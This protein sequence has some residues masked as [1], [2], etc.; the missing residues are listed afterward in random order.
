MNSLS[1]RVAR[2]QTMFFRFVADTFFAG[3]YGHR[4]VVLETIAAVPGMVAGMWLHL[5]SLRKMQTGYGPVIRE[6]LS[7]AENERMHLMFFMEIARPNWFE[8][9]LILVAQCIFWHYYLLLYMFFP[10]T[11]HTMIHYFEQEAVRSYTNYLEML[12]SGEL[13]DVA[14]PP[15]AIKYYDL[16]ADAK[17]SHMVERVRADE[18][19][20]S[21]FNLELSKHED[22][23]NYG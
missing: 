16:P 21:D 3:R 12:L 9:G 1:D 10:K 7:E 17:L 20:H 13:D 6:L 15:L 8:R 18:Q 22:I 11:A 14:A 2:S 19:R 4:A 5:K 23:R